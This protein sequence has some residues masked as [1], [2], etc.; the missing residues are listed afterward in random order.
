[1]RPLITFDVAPPPDPTVP[2][3]VV[4]VAL[5]VAVLLA[6]LVAAIALAI[7]F[8]IRSS[9]KRRTP[10]GPYPPTLGGPGN[11]VDDHPDPWDRR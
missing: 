5:L 6:V 4:V 3:G 10:P 1:M 8:V 9:R 11:R 2:A 7:V